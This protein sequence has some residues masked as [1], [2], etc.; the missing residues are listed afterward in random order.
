M[1]KVLIVDDHMEWAEPLAKLPDLSNHI[2]ELRG[3]GRE[4]LEA[5]E[6]FK[7]DLVVLDLMMP[8]LD[9]LSFLQMLRKRPDGANVRVV[10]FTGY[11]EWVEPSRFA[12]LGVT[13][14]MV[15][16]SDDHAKLVRLIRDL[17]PSESSP[18]G[19]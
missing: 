7:P 2:V 5:I 16:G 13:E 8:V 12:D 6:Q 15:K 17:P 1:A 18:V 4:A 19:A 3:N 9:G 14:F 10:V 11:A